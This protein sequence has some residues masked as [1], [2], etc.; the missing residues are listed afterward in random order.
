MALRREREL[1]QLI[2]DS[3]LELVS[4]RLAGTGHYRATVNTSSGEQ[5]VIITSFSASDKRSMLNMRAH[6][7]RIARGDSSIPGS[8]NVRFVDDGM[9]K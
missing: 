1:R 8:M 4:L 7:R 2:A 5:R 3:G 6:M 9:D